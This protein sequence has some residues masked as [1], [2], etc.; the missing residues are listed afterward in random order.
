[1]MVE[2]IFFTSF[3]SRGPLVLDLDPEPILSQAQHK[4]QDDIIERVMNALDG[5]TVTVL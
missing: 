1:M 2:K 3:S 4:V 5:K